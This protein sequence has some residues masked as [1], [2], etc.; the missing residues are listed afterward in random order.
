MKKKFL[1]L[2]TIIMLTGCDIEYNLT[3]KDNTLSEETNFKVSFEEYQNDGRIK[4]LYDYPHSIYISENI[5]EEDGI[6][7]VEDFT[8]YEKNIINSNGYYNILYK[9]NYEKNNYIES[10]LLN[11]AFTSSNIEINSIN[12]RIIGRDLSLFNNYQS[13]DI[14]KLTVNIAIEDIYQV[15]NHNA[16]NVKNNVYTWIF[17]SDTKQYQDIIFE[18]EKKK[19]IIQNNE[20]DEPDLSVS[21]PNN[22][23]NNYGLYIFL[24]ILVIIVIIGYIWFNKMKEKNNQMDD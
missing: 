4:E 22:K 11:T 18:Y 15:K 24:V 19:T 8:Y 16:N 5:P 7:I 12:G 1:L 10:R 13:Y 3:I 2:I 14:N 6:K 17:Y 9:A 21:T 23:L 20:T